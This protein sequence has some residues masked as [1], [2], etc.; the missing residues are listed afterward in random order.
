MATVLR[1]LVE[2][3]NVNTEEIDDVIVGIVQRPPVTPV[4]AAILMADNTI[5]TTNMYVS[6]WY[7]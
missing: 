6:F 2:R 1:E 4:I 5:W 3:H 7:S